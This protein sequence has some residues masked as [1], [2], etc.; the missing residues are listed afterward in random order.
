ML[1]GLGTNDSLPENLSHDQR[2][3]FELRQAP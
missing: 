3:R 2:S 1:E